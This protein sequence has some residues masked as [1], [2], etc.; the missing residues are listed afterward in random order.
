MALLH[1]VQLHQPLRQPPLQPPPLQQPPLQPP[2]LPTTPAATTQPCSNHP[3]R[4]TPAATTLAATP[5]VAA[6]ATATPAPTPVR[7]A[8]LTV[9]YAPDA[10]ENTDKVLDALKVA[11]VRATLY[12]NGNNWCNGHAPPCSTTLAC[13]KAE[14]QDTAVYAMSHPHVDTLTDAHINTLH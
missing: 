1:L 11:G 13:I 8:V 3:C 5:N 7:F 2:P 14:G 6:A 4:T 9:D 10:G 12:V